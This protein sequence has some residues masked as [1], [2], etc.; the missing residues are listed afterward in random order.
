MIIKRN[1]LYL[2]SFIFLLVIAGCGSPSSVEISDSPASTNSQPPARTPTTMPTATEVVTQGTISIWH[3]W[4]DPQIPALLRS[5]DA[6]GEIYPNVHF[7][8]LYVP[9]LDLRAS[10]EQ[11]AENGGGPTILIGSA[12]WGPDLFDQG[13]VVDIQDLVG[14]DLVNTLNPAAV[15]TTRYGDNMIGLPL[16][17]DGV[18][19]YRNNNIVLGSPATFDELITLAQANSEGEI[20]GA[21]LDRSFFMGGGHLNG[22]GGRLM[23]PEGDPAFNDEK[24]LE[25]IELLKSFEEAGPSD[26]FTDDDSNL[27]KEGRVGFIVEGTWK[28]QE[29]AEAIGESNLSVVTWPIHAGGTLSGYVR[30]ENIYLTPRAMDE[31]QLVS[32]KFIEFLLSPESQTELAEVGLIPAINGSPANLAA[33]KMNVTDRLIRQA[34]LA[35]ADGTTYAVIPEMSAYTA[36]MDIALKSVFIEGVDPVEAL[37]TAERT[38]RMT[39]AALRSTPT[40]AP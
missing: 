21:Y 29:L 19:L 35:L 17:I 13:L 39:L 23:N 12:D 28:R 10:F 4:D 2:I 37:S 7:D 18:V 5:I 30:A 40:P 31:D 38:I 1:L 8:V 32:W 11:V 6:F 9:S 27:F 25:W 3:S 16:N 24:G 36:P 22:L 33:G 20:L 15:G 34:M 14:A 26:Y